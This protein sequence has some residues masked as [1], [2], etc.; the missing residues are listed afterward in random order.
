[1]KIIL[2]L[3]L[4]SVSLIF[5][6]Q[7]Q[8][9]QWDQ[10]KDGK[11]SIT[12]NLS[13]ANNDN[14][15]QALDLYL[16]KKPTSG[17]PLPVIAFIHG[18]AWRAGD[19][20]SGLWRLRPFIASGNYA[21]MSIGYRLTNEA[22]WP[23]QIHDCKAAIRWI[24]ANAQKYNLNPD[25]IAVWGT[26]AGGHL[27]AM[28]GTT[29]EVKELEGTIG[30]HLNHSSRVNAVVNFF[31]PAEILTMGDHPSS[32]DHNA[33]GS[34]ESLLI[35][36]PILENQDKARSA[37]PI[38]HITKDAPP[39]LNIHG[40]ADAL[41]PYQQS[42]SFNQKLVEAGV[43]SNLITIT[44]GGHGNFGNAIKQ[45]NRSVA[46]FLSKHLRS[47]QSITIKDQ[48]LQAKTP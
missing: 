39:T 34:P 25:K 27:V 12:S 32:I 26:S 31:G 19:K 38:T 1:M 41:V 22:Q 24:R 10:N 16:P 21:G 7:H 9:E 48:T 46:N 2:A 37:S 20:R 42:V 30:T 18:G 23:S 29:G 40:T 3:L 35:G 6:Q 36:G 11:L 17:Q 45:V 4:T 43:S 44:D 13:Y 47:D 5:G 33:P 28:L 8:L 14:P 15:R